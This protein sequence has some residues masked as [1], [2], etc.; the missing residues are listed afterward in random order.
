MREE[1]CSMRASGARFNDAIGEVMREVNALSETLRAQRL[2]ALE[3]TALLRAVMEEID[4]AVFTFDDAQKLKLVNRAGERL[5][6]RPAERLLDL[7]AEE[8]ALARCLEGAAA[9]TMEVG[10]PGGSGRWAM[11]RG[12]F[13]QGGRPHQLIVLTDLSRA[14]REEERLA[15]QRLIRVMG[16]GLNKSLAPIQS[17]AQSLESQL[18]AAISNRE[19]Q[20]AGSS[21]VLEVKRQR[22]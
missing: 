18:R 7:T 10:F 22:P 2:G 15:W 13:R 9:R 20:S 14:L 6:G 11:R 12:T 5:L 8:L 16:H 17:V 4:V 3:A 1:D 21:E 19:E